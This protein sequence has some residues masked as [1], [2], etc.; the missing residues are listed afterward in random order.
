MSPGTWKKI[1]WTTAAIIVGG[2]IFL[3]RG[4]TVCEDK[5]TTNGPNQVVQTCRPLTITDPQVAGTLFLAVLFLLP[6]LAEVGIPG[7]LTLKRRVEEQEAKVEEQE[8]RIAALTAQVAQSAVQ[9]QTAEQSSLAQG[10]AVNVNFYDFE[11]AIRAWT[12]RETRRPR[13]RGLRSA[14]DPSARRWSTSWPAW[15]KPL[16]PSRRSPYTPT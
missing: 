14:P 2:A 3:S 10:N 7:L 12:D 11:A 5:L 4:Q 8:T 13:G 6:D 16:P 9:Q 15:G 1:R